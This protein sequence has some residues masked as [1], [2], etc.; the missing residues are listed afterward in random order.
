MLRRTTE[1]LL[2][3]P[4]GENQGHHHVEAH[5][6]SQRPSY[7][8][9]ASGIVRSGTVASL[10]E[11]MRQE[12]QIRIRTVPRLEPSHLPAYARLLS[13]ADDCTRLDLSTEEDIPEL[14]VMLA[15]QDVKVYEVQIERQSL[16]EIFLAV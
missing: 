8:A 11:A 4:P 10:Q 7:R 16:E 14:L 6:W 13:Q 2:V 15:K 12:I 5:V 3:E 9:H 1:C